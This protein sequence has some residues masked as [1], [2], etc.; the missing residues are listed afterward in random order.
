LTRRLDVA[1]VGKWKL[2][3]NATHKLSRQSCP[4]ARSLSNQP[5]HVEFFPAPAASFPAQS[6]EPDGPR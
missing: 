4:Q 2:A 5:R 3:S 6:P 1:L